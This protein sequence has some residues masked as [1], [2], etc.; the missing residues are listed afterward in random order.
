MQSSY[1]PEWFSFNRRTARSV[2]RPGYRVSLAAD[3]LLSF[4]LLPCLQCVITRHWPCAKTVI[5][6]AKT[7]PYV[8]R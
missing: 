4:F 2:P 7:F 3:L 8:P 6:Q 1:K 5:W